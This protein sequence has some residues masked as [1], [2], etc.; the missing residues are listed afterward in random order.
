MVLPLPVCDVTRAGQCVLGVLFPATENENSTSTI[1]SASVVSP[2]VREESVHITEKYAEL[3]ET[4]S[5]LRG[6]VVAFSGGVDST[7]LAVASRAVL[8]DRA[9]AVH[10]I[11]DLSPAGETQAARA[12]ASELGLR[13]EEIETRELADARLA[14]NPPDRCYHCKSELFTQLRR[15]ADTQDLDVIL[16]GANFDD[17]DDHRPGHRAARES[18]VRSPLQECR[19][20]KADVRRAAR[21]L[22]LPNWDKPSMACLASRIPFGTPITDDA[23]AR[24]R[25]AEERV[26]ALGFGQVRI[27]AHGDVARIELPA[28]DVERAVQLRESIS[29]L[30]RGAG[31]RWVSLDLDGYRSGSLNPETAEI[32]ETGPGPSD[33]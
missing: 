24:V 21:L 22:A 7:L 32:G 1:Y 9:L 23:I 19:M 30:T 8:G 5:P 13:Y 28:E 20:T 25:Q 29:E 14:S 26:S 6:V 10:A 3:L 2:N 16:D 31:F 4:L 15:L 11:S 33:A 17:L 12:L 18:G 27:R